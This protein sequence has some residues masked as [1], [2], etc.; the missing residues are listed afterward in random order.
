MWEVVL[1]L[2]EVVLWLRLLE[3]GQRC[4]E[5]RA[6]NLTRWL[7]CKVIRNKSVLRLLGEG[8]LVAWVEV[9]LW[10]DRELLLLD[11]WACNGAVEALELFLL[12]ERIVNILLEWIE[13]WWLVKAGLSDLVLHRALELCLSNVL[14]RCN[15]NGVLC[16]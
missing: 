11:Q 9:G 13:L 15:G 4:I 16:K 7:G 5:L 12:G 6:L 3:V 1:W 8:D 14:L 2:L 10:P